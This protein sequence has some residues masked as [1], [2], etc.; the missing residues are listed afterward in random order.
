[1]CL[2]SPGLMDP[3]NIQDVPADRPSAQA[4]R[5]RTCTLLPFAQ[6]LA[7]KTSKRKN[8]NLQPG[9]TTGW[10]H[11]KAT[12][13]VCASQRLM[14]TPTHFSLLAESFVFSH[15]TPTPLQTELSK[16]KKN[17]SNQTGKKYPKSKIAAKKSIWF[18]LRQWFSETHS[19]NSGTG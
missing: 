6:S 17:P 7:R 9:S 11:F 19:V 3:P 15:A 13:A 16:R 4:G 1:M 12:D 5:W 2:V 8:N 18:T 14:Q 10:R